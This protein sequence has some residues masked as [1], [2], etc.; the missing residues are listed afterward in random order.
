MTIA[1][2]FFREDQREAAAAS[3]KKAA[4]SGGKKGRLLGL[5]PARKAEKPEASEQKRAAQFVAGAKRKERS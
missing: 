2:E 3:G 1:S 5:N 4:L